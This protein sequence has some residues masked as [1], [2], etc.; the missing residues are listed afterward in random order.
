MC[1]HYWLY[2]AQNNA[3]V[4]SKFLKPNGQFVF[5]EQKAA[6]C[7]QGRRDQSVIYNLESEFERSDEQPD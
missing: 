1:E 4:V 2:S 3:N 6:I 5:V 7:K